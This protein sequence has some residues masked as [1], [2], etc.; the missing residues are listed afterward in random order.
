[1]AC[2]PP[3]LSLGNQQRV[4]LAAALVHDPAALVLDEPFSGLD[5]IGVDALVFVAA[6]IYANAVLRTSARVR[7][8]EAWRAPQS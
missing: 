2:S 5:P 3:T 8:R 6:R 1:L 7:L 4:Q